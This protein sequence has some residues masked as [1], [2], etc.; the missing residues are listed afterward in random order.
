MENTLFLAYVPKTRYDFEINNS[1]GSEQGYVTL[2]VQ[3][4][5]IETGETGAE[6]VTEYTV[7]LESKPVA[8]EKFG[9]YVAGLHSQN[10]TFEAQY[11]VYILQLLSILWDSSCM[12]T[13]IVDTPEVILLK[14]PHSGY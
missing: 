10:N 9:E 3:G 8:L 6:A 7:N 2:V 11:K 4:C 13:H 14:V 5:E 12:H 1:L